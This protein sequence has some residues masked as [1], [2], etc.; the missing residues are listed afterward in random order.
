MNRRHDIFKA[1]INEARENLVEAFHN[2]ELSREANENLERSL[3]DCAIHISL[4]LLELS[5]IEK[6][7]EGNLKPITK[8]AAD[9]IA[10]GN[11]EQ[12]LRIPMRLGD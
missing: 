8:R 9:D 4:I 12:F 5:L 6:I 7:K 1:D 10:V 3:L 11:W 2:L